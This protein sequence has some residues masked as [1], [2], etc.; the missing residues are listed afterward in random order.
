MEGGRALPM[1]VPIS[2][3]LRSMQHVGHYSKRWVSTSADHTEAQ[4]LGPT[5]SPINDH[6][7]PPRRWTN[8]LTV[9]PTSHWHAG[10]VEVG[11][12]KIG[13]PLMR[14]NLQAQESW[15]LHQSHV[16]P[17]GGHIRPRMS[18]VVVVDTKLT[19]KTVNSGGHTS[20]IS[21]HPTSSSLVRHNICCI[22]RIPPTTARNEIHGSV[23][24]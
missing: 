19:D 10:V 12:N 5:P 9:S 13:S 17:Q 4:T 2:I 7:L 21:I 23:Y 11:I 1:I 20:L 3:L 15:S 8:C 24:Q 14:L 22:I 6:P 16:A 18:V